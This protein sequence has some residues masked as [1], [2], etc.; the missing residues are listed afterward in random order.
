MRSCRTSR[1]RGRA[2]RQP[3]RQFLVPRCRARQQ[4]V[5]DVGAHDQ[6]HE[7]DDRGQDRCAADVRGVHVVDAAL[8]RV[9]DQIGNLGA[10]PVTDGVARR[11]GQP[12]EIRI[13]TRLRGVLKH[14]S[15][16]R[17]H[18]R[19]RHTRL[20]APH[21][22]KPP[23]GRTGEAL[24]LRRRS[25]RRRRRRIQLRVQ[26]QRQRDVRSLR[27]RLLH[28]GELRR[29]DADNRDHD[30]VDTN[31][32]A[33]HGGIGREPRMPVLRADHRHRRSRRLIVVGKDGA[34]DPRP[35]AERLVVVAGGDERGCNLGLAIDDHVD[36]SVRREREELAHGLVVG[37][38]LL[39]HRKRERRPDVLTVASTV[40][41]AVVA[42]AGDH[43]VPA[44]IPEPDQG[45]GVLDRDPG[46]QQRV[47]P[48]KMAVLAPIPEPGT[49]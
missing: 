27:N 2:E 31:G 14:G 49:G 41:V 33:E 44:A 25:A 20:Q 28:A 42:R 5:G 38:E 18:L 35:D 36:A 10:A 48:E 26:R 22:L 34:T 3:H 8:R 39:V 24:G 11:V 6:Q 21:D 12:L 32:L 23:V 13:E 15:E 29:Q 37:Q 1:A 19:R 45:V 47:H 16:I 4:Q 46:Q 30:V 17:L 9:D 40:G 43:V 7:R